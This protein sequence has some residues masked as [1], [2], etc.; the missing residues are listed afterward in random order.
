M[1]PPLSGR[2]G[3][4]LDLPS[5]ASVLQETINS[6]G[7]SLDG[8]S[9][10][11]PS[12]SRRGSFQKQATLGDLPAARAIASASVLSMAIAMPP[13]EPLE[14]TIR[15]RRARRASRASHDLGDLPAATAI[16]AASDLASDLLTDLSQTY[17]GSSVEPLPAELLPSTSRIAPTWM[18]HEMGNN[19]ID[20][21]M[22]SVEPTPGSMDA[23]IGIFPPPS[24]LMYRPDQLVSIIPSWMT[25]FGVAPTKALPS[26]SLP[27]PPRQEAREH[28][29]SAQELERQAQYIGKVLDSCSRSRHWAL[30]RQLLDCRADAVV[31]DGVA[32]EHERAAR[33]EAARKL[34][35]NRVAVLN[36]VT[37]PAPMTQKS[38]RRVSHPQLT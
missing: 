16:Y 25:S 6:S 3:T 24:A 14:L 17:S 21:A 15:S 12:F 37:N 23:E 19:A 29:E 34:I 31:V 30:L 2:D 10:V 1:D 18:P 26:L 4:A 20:T 7:E 33:E 22:P 35:M 28:V 27:L 36:D 11:S 13:T 5:A 32:G 9:A 38:L 8:S